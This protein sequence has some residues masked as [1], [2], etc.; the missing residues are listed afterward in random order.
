MVFF[1]CFPFLFT[2]SLLAFFLRNAHALALCLLQHLDGGVKKAS[3]FRPISHHFPVPSSVN[4]NPKANAQK[5]TISF[6]YDCH[7][8]HMFHGSERAGQLEKI[9]GFWKNAECH[10]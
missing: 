7:R 2:E 6:Y 10:N 9:T 5:G 4:K 1:I 8:I 3:P